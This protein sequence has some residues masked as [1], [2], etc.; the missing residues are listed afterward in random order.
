MTIRLKSTEKVKVWDY[1]EIT[2]GIMVSQCFI[3]CV[4]S[5]SKAMRPKIER[6][7][8]KKEEE[9][10]Q[11]H[12]AEK[13]NPTG[14]AFRTTP[15]PQMTSLRGLALPSSSSCHSRASSLTESPTGAQHPTV[16]KFWV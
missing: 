7:K 10:E 5:F 12:S 9:H 16:A 6:L 1:A 8:K 2:A 15:P 14:T 3:F 11:R 4:Q 13:A